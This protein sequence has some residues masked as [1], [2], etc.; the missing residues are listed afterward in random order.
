MAKRTCSFPD[1]DGTQRARG[2]CDAHYQQWRLTGEVKPKRWAK[3]GGPCVVCGGKVPTG[4]GRRKHCSGACQQVDFRTKGTRP[5][6]AT[7]D[8][9][10][11]SF[12]LGRERTGR[13]Q[14]SDTKWC[15][16]C[17]R[18][19]P[20]VQR[21]RRYGITS[22]QYESAS[23][24]GCAICGALDRKLHID[25]DHACC[26]T[27]G[28]HGPATCGKCVRGLIC[29]PCNRGLGLFQDDAE[30]LRRAADYLTEAHQRTRG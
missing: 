18:N 8:F 17:G 6:S 21:F 16:D 22:E 26:P 5:T 24:K 15:P 12:S 19:S 7:C 28:G 10:G 3:L 27:H 20:D 11:T 13:L 29:G 25:H 23:A 2:W 1:C 9:C 30:S 4:Q 14:R